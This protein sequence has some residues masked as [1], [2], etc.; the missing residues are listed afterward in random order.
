M[1]Q[2][3][4]KKPIK[5]MKHESNFGSSFGPFFRFFTQLTMLLKNLNTADPS[6]HAPITISQS[7]IL[8]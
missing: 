8:L 7:G 5:E 6:P 1:N 2:T 4:R 3:K